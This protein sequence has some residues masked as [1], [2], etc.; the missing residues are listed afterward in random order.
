LSVDK[1]VVT[2]RSWD[3]YALTKHVYVPLYITAS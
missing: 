3:C 1:H 2:T